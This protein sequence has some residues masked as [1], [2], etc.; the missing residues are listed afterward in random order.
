MRT[1]RY[2]TASHTPASDKDNNTTRLVGKNTWGPFAPP[3]P[4]FTVLHSLS[5]PPS[6]FPNTI[7]IANR[8]LTYRAN[9]FFLSFPVLSCRQRAG[10]H[11]DPEH[12]ARSHSR[13]WQRHHRRRLSARW[14]SKRGLAPRVH[15]VCVHFKFAPVVCSCLYVCC[16]P[17]HRFF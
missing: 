14:V 5:W 16:C 9:S 4:L 7:A 15:V 8:R 6:S 12:L 3:S 2:R 13:P 1:T 11:Y 10:P 17:C